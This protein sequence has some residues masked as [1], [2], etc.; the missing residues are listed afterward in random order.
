MTAFPGIKLAFFTL[1][2][3]LAEVV[4]MRSLYK[5]VRKENEMIVSHRL[6]QGPCD[7][8]HHA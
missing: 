7:E 2:R 8:T 4:D 6:Q 3:S 5:D 1:M